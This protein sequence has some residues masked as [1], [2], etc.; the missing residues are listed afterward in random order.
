MRNFISFIVPLLASLQLFAQQQIT[1][2][3][4]DTAAQQ[5]IVAAT[6]M[7]KDGSLGT[8][9]NES[10][11]FSLTVPALPAALIISAAGYGAKEMTIAN[12]QPVSVS[13]ASG[14]FMEAVW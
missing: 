8:Y 13:M 3:V 14:S 4:I 7:L 5:P 10:G 9:T 12:N 2:K 1:G 11:Q 6:V